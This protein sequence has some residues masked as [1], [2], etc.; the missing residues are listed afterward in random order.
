MSSRSSTQS[1]I[2]KERQLL[3]RV[4]E[5]E[6]N[7]FNINLIFIGIFLYFLY[8]SMG[9]MFPKTDFSKKSLLSSLDNIVP[10]FTISKK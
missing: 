3:E 7:K 8:I 6:G 2:Q 1:S 5:C 4:Q 10:D 9:T